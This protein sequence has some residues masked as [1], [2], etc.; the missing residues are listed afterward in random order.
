MISSGARREARGLR[1]SY[2]EQVSQNVWPKG[3]FVETVKVWQ[4][5]WFYITEP[6]DA[7]WAAAPNFR[8]GP[9]MRLSSWTTKGLDGGPN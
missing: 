5:E 1:R 7:K 2:G 9:S 8:F 6:H 4:Q 3:A